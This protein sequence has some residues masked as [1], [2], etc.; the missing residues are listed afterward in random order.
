MTP[1][2]QVHLDAS[3]LDELVERSRRAEEDLQRRLAARLG[4]AGLD[5]ANPA[6]PSD[7]VAKRLG[8]LLTKV[9][10]ERRIV[11]RKLAMRRRSV[12]PALHNPDEPDGERRTEPL[13]VN[14]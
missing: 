9:R 4:F 14:R 11:E 1:I 7:P 12:P 5:Q 3:H 10:D 13:P 8:F 6:P 2:D